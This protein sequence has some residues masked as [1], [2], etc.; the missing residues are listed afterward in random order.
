MV[1]SLMSVFGVKFSVTYVNVCGVLWEDN[2]TPELSF[3]PVREHC[4][5]IR[6]VLARITAYVAYDVFISIHLYCYHCYY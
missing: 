5:D 6:Q 2:L 4:V 3:A 1:L